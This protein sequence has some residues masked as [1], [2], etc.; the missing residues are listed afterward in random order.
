MLY[1][2]ASEKEELT[3]KEKEC[4]DN[5]SSTEKINQVDIKS[6]LAYKNQNRQKA[7]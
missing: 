3:K 7:F 4:L 6:A 1:V 5:V 2:C